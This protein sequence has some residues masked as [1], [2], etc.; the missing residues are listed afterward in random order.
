MAEVS[1]RQLRN[2]GGSIIERVLEGEL[3]TVTKAGQ[4]V[5]ELV[6]LRRPHLTARQIVERWNA[7]PALDIQALRDDVDALLVPDL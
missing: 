1:V 3:I 5:A 6:P 4:P 7:V 2:E